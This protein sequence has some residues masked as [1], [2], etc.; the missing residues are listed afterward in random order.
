MS[1]ALQEDSLPAEPQGKARNSEVGSLSLLPG[2]SLTQGS[3]RGLL[4]CRQTLYQL[5]YQVACLDDSRKKS[6]LFYVHKFL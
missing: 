6:A 4:R 5:S 2:I 1:P 3:N